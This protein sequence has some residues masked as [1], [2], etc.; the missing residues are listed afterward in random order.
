MTEQQRPSLG[1]GAS[2]FMEQTRQENL[3]SKLISVGLLSAAGEG[4]LPSHEGEQ[5]NLYLGTQNAGDIKKL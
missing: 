4:K 5:I 2:N 3:S 1:P